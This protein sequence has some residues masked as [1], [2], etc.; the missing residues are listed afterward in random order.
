MV[1]YIGSKRA[2]LPWILGTIDKVASLTGSKVVLDLFSGTSRVAHGLKAKG[3]YSGG[4]RPLHL[5]PTSWPRPLV[6]ADAR[7]YPEEAVAPLLAELASL[8]SQAGL[9]HPPLLPGGPVLPGGELRA[10]R[11]GQGGH[12]GAL[13]GDGPRGRAPHQPPPR[14]GQGGLHGGGPD[15][16]PSRGGPPGRTAPSASSTRPLLP[17]EGPALQG[18]AVEVAKEVEGDIAYLDPP[19]N[20]HSYLGNY[21]VWE[22]LV[23]WGRARG[24]RGGPEALW[25]SGGGGAPLASRSGAERALEGFWAT[26]GRGTWVLSYSDEGFLSLGGFPRSCRAGGTPPASPGP[27]GGTWGPSSGSTAPRAS[28]WGAPAPPGT[29]SFYS[30]R[31][32]RGGWW[33]PSSRRVRKVPRP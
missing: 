15:G 12:K 10:H 24:V 20:G 18:D 13:L 19:Y 6:E 4:Q 29:R 16:L 1:K 14:S 21:H 3:Y 25:T 17:G 5:R 32:R 30:W 8:P 27:T 9:V 26:S 23:L 31:A 7:R 28:G 2:L 33:R 22:T 11:G